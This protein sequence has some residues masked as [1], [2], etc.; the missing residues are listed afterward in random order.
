MP[1]PCRLRALVRGCA[2]SKV[3]DLSHVVDDGL[4]FRHIGGGREWP[5]LRSLL[6][7]T[8]QEAQDDLVATVASALR[9]LPGIET[10]SVDA[11]DKEIFGGWGIRL[12]LKPTNI[13]L[14]RR[15]AQVISSGAS[16]LE[17]RKYVPPQGLIRQWK[18]AVRRQW[19]C[20]VVCWLGYL[21]EDAAKGDPWKNEDNGSNLQYLKDTW[22][23]VMYETEL[24][25]LDSG[26]ESRGKVQ[27]ITA[28][29]DRKR[30]GWQK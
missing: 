23:Q 12:N 22:E 29:R 7:S 13:C 16:L 3:L 25:Q 28:R 24:V 20:E 11:V 4:F 26:G 27:R 14:P 15:T 9:N 19:G 21:H 2:A 5:R 18:E 30:R 1:C 6:V 8:G 17:L 10:M